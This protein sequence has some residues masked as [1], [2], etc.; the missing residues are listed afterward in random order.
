VGDE[1]AAAFAAAARRYVA[2]VDSAPE[3]DPELLLG[4]LAA[5]L[6]VL[7]EA[8]LQ[9]PDVAGEVD[10]PSGEARVTAGQWKDVFDR[11]QEGLPGDDY[12]WTVEPSIEEEPVELAGS[13]ADDLADIYAD[14]KPGL[15]FVAAGGS[16][17]SAAREWRLSFWSHWGTHAVEALRVIHGRLA[18]G[19]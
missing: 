13:L 7:Y 18:A 9:L 3:R 17:S 5:L 2:A 4:D 16:T 6:P 15:D 8:A 11:L 19:G 12:Y 14:V 10:E 1:R